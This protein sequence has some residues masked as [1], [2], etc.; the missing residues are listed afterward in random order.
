MGA[1]T[2]NCVT[3]GNPVTNRLIANGSSR[4]TAT[5]TSAAVNAVTAAAFRREDNK[6][7]PPCCTTPPSSSIQGPTSI[8]VLVKAARAVVQ[9]E[10]SAL[11]LKS[12]QRST[13]GIPPSTCNLPCS[14]LALNC[15]DLE[16]SVPLSALRQATTKPLVS[17][18]MP[19]L[20]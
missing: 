4:V 5:T 14:T 16:L 8:T 19:R 12:G 15:S 6:V 2:P 7:P 1:L 9:T 3:A 18:R 17:S 10:V 11:C 13:R 20:K